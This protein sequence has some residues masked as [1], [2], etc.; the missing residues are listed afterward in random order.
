[1]DLGSE[2]DLSEE[3][4]E[5]FAARIDELLSS[6]LEDQA[7]EQHMMLETVHAARTALGD[8]LAELRD[9]RQLVERRD[10]AVI[11][12]LEARL[13]GVGTEESIERLGRRLEEVADQTV[14]SEAVD[15]VAARIEAIE[16]SL[17]ALDPRA[18]A[19]ELR[20][21]ITGRLRETAAEVGD[22]SRTVEGFSSA[23]REAL[24]ALNDAVSSLRELTASESARVT[25]RVESG[26]AGFSDRLASDA[27]LSREALGEKI[28]QTA[29]G[30][31]E[32]LASG[33]GDLAASV[34]SLRER[35]AQTDTAIRMAAEAL[36]ARLQES[37]SEAREAAERTAART[38]DRLQRLQED[39]AELRKAASELL[40]S[41]D[42]RLSEERQAAREAGAAMSRQIEQV[43]DAVAARLPQLEASIGSQIGDARTAADARLVEMKSALTGELGKLRGAIETQLPEIGEALAKQL[44]TV[45]QTVRSQAPETAATVGSI[46]DPFAEEMG[47]FAERLRQA[48]MR[49]AESNSRVE[50]LQ[51]SLVAYLAQRDERLEEVRVRVLADLIERLGE[52]L[53][54]RDRVR[55]GE[56]MREAEQR[57]KD[58]HDAERYRR[59]RAKAAPPSEGTAEQVALEMQKAAEGAAAAPKAPARRR[60]SKPG[61][62]KAKTAAPGAAARRRTKPRS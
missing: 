16:G 35:V 21:A 27:A 55:I 12:L 60:S 19:A 44:E 4:A 20:E 38:F 48:N 45:R 17:A 39:L 34:E 54:H 42:A 25:E 30:L 56:A 50:A 14:I 49:I 26:L 32:R 40:P 58:R 10:Q 43:R 57:R 7:R 8:A 53:K 41:I 46:L 37:A 29:R 61:A 15:P 31:E 1:M 6:A 24:D 5:G 62:R 2:N 13:S 33:M 47:K 11:D 9:L 22:L 28:R 18:P 23:M 3:S 52:V 36:E 59:L 51:E